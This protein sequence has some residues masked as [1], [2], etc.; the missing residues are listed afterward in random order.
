MPK[1]EYVT[2]LFEPDG[3]HL[4]GESTNGSIVRSFYWNEMLDYFPASHSTTADA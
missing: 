3:Q 4:C 2:Y 1:H